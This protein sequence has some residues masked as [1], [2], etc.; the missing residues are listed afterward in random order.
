MSTETRRYIG[1][2][3]PAL[4][5]PLV[6]VGVENNEEKKVL[7]YEIHVFFEGMIKFYKKMELISE[8]EEQS[9]VGDYIDITNR[10]IDD[11]IEK[12]ILEAMES[13]NIPCHLFQPLQSVEKEKYFMHVL[14]LWARECYD[15]EVRDIAYNSKFFKTEFSVAIKLPK[16]KVTISAAK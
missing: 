4:G 6:L 3:M 9:Q 12:I 16:M 11:E 15:E 13:K 14:S 1:S 5:T 8:Y 7:F 10:I 2:R